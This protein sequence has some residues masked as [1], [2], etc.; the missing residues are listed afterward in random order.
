MTLSFSWE[1]ER[2]LTQTTNSYSKISIVLVVTATAALKSK[3]TL[4]TSQG[5]V[6]FFFFWYE[7]SCFLI[8]IIKII[9]HTVELER[10]SWHFRCF[11]NF[12]F[13]QL[14]P[15]IF[16]KVRTNQTKC[17]LILWECSGCFESHGLTI[18][19][20]LWLNWTRNLNLKTKTILFAIKF[21]WW[22]HTLRAFV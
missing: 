15:T 18:F 17:K 1:R 4:P 20:Y 19:N 2:E 11:Y 5:V 10:D 21:C 3:C 14:W 22:S 13:V 8:L 9:F 7:G 12:F 16:Y 6:F